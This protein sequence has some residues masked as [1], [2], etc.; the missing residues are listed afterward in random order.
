MNPDDTLQA[1]TFEDIEKESTTTIKESVILGDDATEHLSDAQLANCLQTL[2][3]KFKV[4]NVIPDATEMSGRI[5]EKTQQQSTNENNH[6]TYP[7]SSHLT[8]GNTG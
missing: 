2:N 6:E 4:S 5:V 7:E 8:L 1:T 3:R